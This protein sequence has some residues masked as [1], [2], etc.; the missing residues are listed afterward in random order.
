MHPQ[1]S[2][3][4]GSL[5]CTPPPAQILEILSHVNKRVKAAKALHLPLWPLLALAIGTPATAPDLLAPTAGAAASDGGTGAAA[6]P[7]ANPMVRN[8]ALVYSEMAFERA[9]SEEQAAAVSA[10]HNGGGGGQ[11]GGGGGAC[12]A[13]RRLG[14]DSIRLQQGVRMQGRSRGGCIACAQML[15]LPSPICCPCVSLFLSAAG[16]AG[17]RTVRPECAAPSH[18]PAHGR[19]GHGEP[20]PPACLLLYPGPC[21]PAAVRPTFRWGGAGVEAL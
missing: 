17:A 19:R 11:A 14:R 9:S 7:A 10:A 4:T 16:C 13:L 20:R 18:Q 8:F 15:P 21:T 3:R 12:T 6:G 1:S 5:T 2:A